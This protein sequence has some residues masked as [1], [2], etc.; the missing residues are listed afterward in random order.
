MPPRSSRPGLT[1]LP[2]L[3]D[4]EEAIAVGFFARQAVPA[5]TRWRTDWTAR[6]VLSQENRDA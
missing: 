6:P 1:T 2:S 5:S 4:D 3:H